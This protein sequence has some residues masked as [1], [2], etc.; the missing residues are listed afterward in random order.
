[1]TEAERRLAY[2]EAQ[3]NHPDPQLRPLLAWI[4]GPDLPQ[5][6]ASVEWERAEEDRATKPPR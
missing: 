3:T 1:M 2:A 4:F 6:R 5:L